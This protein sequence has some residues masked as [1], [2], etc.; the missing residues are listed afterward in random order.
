MSQ[1]ARVGL[2]HH[3]RRPRQQEKDGTDD[4][5]KRDEP[6]ALRPAA[7]VDGRAAAARGGRG[8]SGEIAT[9]SAAQQHAKAAATAE[10]ARQLHL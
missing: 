8:E 3:A 2:L 10:A 4:L 7:Q 9:S 6:G 1:V 5:T